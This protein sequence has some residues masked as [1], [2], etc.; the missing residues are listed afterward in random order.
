MPVQRKLDC[1]GYGPWSEKEGQIHVQPPAEILAESVIFR[2]HL[3]ECGEENGPLK[4]L[5]KSHLMGRMKDADVT[6]YPKDGAVSCTVKCGDAVLLKPLT[7]HASAPSQRPGHRRVVH[8]EFSKAM[9]PGGMAWAG[10]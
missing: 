2:V 8:L 1:A 6:S 3:D 9:L 4:V 10:Q 7:L 5:S